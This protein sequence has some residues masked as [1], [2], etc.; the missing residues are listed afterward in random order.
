M[1]YVYTIEYV[2]N[3]LKVPNSKSTQI[4]SIIGKT[5]RII[6]TDYKD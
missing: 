2:E 6:T 5:D 4:L 1:P 3:N